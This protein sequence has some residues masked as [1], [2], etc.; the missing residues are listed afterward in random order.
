MANIFTNSQIHEYPLKKT[1]IFFLSIVSLLSINAQEIDKKAFKLTQKGREFLKARN[2]PK[3]IDLFYQALES[4]SAYHKPYEQL[5]IALKIM[6]NERA[7][8]DLQLRYV[9][10]VPERNLDNRVW[11]T[12]AAYEFAAG[13]YEK[14]KGYLLNV[15]NRD[16]IFATSVDFAL[17]EI[18]KEVRLAFDEMPQQV[19][20]FAFQYLP[21]L[22]ID[23]RTL[24]FTA[25]ERFN[26]DEDIYQTLFD[27]NVWSEASPISDEI[28]SPYNE[29]ACAISA[30]GRTLVLTA[31]EGRQTFG[32]CDLYITTKIGNN[33]NPL[34]NLGRTINSRSWDS[35]PSLSADGKT[36]Y[37]SS[38]RPGG[39]GGKDLW[40]SVFKEGKWIEP[41]NL[42]PEINTKKHETSPFIHADGKS[43]FFS[44]NGH[45]GMGGFDLYQS[46]FEE[47][48][49][50][51]KNLGYPLNTFHDEFGLFIT[52]DGQEAYFAKERTEGGQLI[53]SRLMTYK[54]EEK[55]LVPKVNYLTGMVFDKKTGEKLQ[56]EIEIVNLN[57]G[58]HTY[59]TKSDPIT[60]TYFLTLQNNGDFAAFVEK[61]GYLHDEISFSTSSGLST[62]TLN[63]YLQP[64]E[65][66]AS[67]V[68]KNIYFESDS[69][70]LNE[71]S[72]EEL[73]KVVQLMKKNPTIKIEI[74]GHTDNT[75]SEQYNLDLSKRRARRVYDFLLASDIDLWRLSY[76][77]YGHSKPL[78]ANQT[79][80]D[81][82]ANRRIEFKVL[83][84]K[85]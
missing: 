8:Y 80:Q 20:K 51:P 47:D 39:Q 21:V 37:F 67:I 2:F 17:H 50:S 82:A 81:R 45:I 11:Q 70:T 7:I 84:L 76:R 83:A 33:W 29:G 58:K 75:G 3:A 55:S 27:G 36:L 28:N 54:L 10:N 19:N 68:L 14:A 73:S 65:K 5:F 30:D 85:R 1:F 12:L 59:D 74:S 15:K 18:K 61:E 25:R 6:S 44:S 66:G 23:K 56:A 40:K 24:I 38:D 22:T 72:N 77:G 79:N 26:S 78:N 57:S 42:G 62:D 46:S 13:R 71:K 35:Q 43:L 69:D 4:D 41:V 53:Y 48:W 31:C 16:P 52:S 64:I 60:G 32:N 63:F 49:N 9:R 34:K